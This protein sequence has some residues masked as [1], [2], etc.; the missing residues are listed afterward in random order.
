MLELDPTLLKPGLIPEHQV[1]M[2]IIWQSGDIRLTEC[3]LSFITP[4]IHE[5]ISLVYECTNRHGDLIHLPYPG[6]ISDQPSRFR[7][8]VDIVRRE[9]N[10]WNIKQMQ[11]VTK[12]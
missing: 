7:E 3:P 4:D 12:K 11:K 8:A 1:S 6:L 10:A 5:L 9:R 2:A